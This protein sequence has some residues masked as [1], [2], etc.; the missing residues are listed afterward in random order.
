MKTWDISSEDIDRIAIGAGILG[1]GGGGSSYLGQLKAKVHLS[2]G[3]K[4]KVVLP[5]DLPDD[6]TVLPLGGIGAPTVSIERIDEGA[7]RNPVDRG[8][9]MR[10][11]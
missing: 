8:N 7:R 9:R 10:L 11:G 2:E 1:T 3:M 6:A 4:I 5:D